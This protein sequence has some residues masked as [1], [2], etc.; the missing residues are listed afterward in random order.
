MFTQQFQFMLHEFEQV[1]R[2]NPAEARRRVHVRETLRERR[3][4]RSRSLRRLMSVLICR[5]SRRPSAPCSGA[6][7]RP[8][9]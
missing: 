7:V 5:W 9:R 6:S 2:E 1:Q 8:A 4:V 3:D